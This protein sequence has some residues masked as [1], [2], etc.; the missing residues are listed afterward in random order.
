MAWIETKDPRE[1]PEVMAAMMAQRHLYPAEY[2]RPD[3][4]SKLPSAVANESIVMSHSLIPKALEHAFSTFG[5]LT[6]PDLPLSRR[7]HELI[8]ATVSTLNSCFY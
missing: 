7:D 1:N 2:G 6:Q 3:A 8:A 4:E 5:V